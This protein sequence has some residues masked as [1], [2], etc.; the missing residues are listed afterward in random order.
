MKLFQLVFYITLYVHCV[1]CFWFY[2]VQID[3]AWVPNQDAFLKNYNFYDETNYYQYYVVFFN[4]VILLTGNDI[5]PVGLFQIFLAVGFLTL[6]AVINA[7]IFG[8][9]AVLIL[10]MNRK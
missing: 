9:M 8:N 1:A 5:N 4:S 2:V 7:T 3:N 10:D 6:G